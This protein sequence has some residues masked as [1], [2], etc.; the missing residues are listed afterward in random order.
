MYTHHIHIKAY[1]HTNIQ[2]PVNTLANTDRHTYTFT[3]THKC[4]QACTFTH[5]CTPT[6]ACT[7]TTTHTDLHAC[8]HT[9]T[10]TQP[11]SNSRTDPCAGSAPDTPWVCTARCTGSGHPWTVARHCSGAT[12]TQEW[13]VTI[14]NIVQH[15]GKSV[16]QAKTNQDK[17]IFCPFPGTGYLA[18]RM[19]PE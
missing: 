19:H 3:H 18:T 1:I 17:K 12:C 2:P 8:T 4:T 10:G 9:H 7:H 6:H 5:T 14:S 11:H 15:P 16:P 13:G